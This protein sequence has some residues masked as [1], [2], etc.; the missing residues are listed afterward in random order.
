LVASGL[1]PPAPQRYPLAEGRAAL[2]ALAAGEV[3]GKVIL[4][5]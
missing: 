5:P 2:E 4:E 3:Y 1:R